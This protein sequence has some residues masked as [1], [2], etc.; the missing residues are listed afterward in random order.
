M[1]L[2]VVPS[3]KLLSEKNCCHLSL[4]DLGRI[5]EACFEMAS[6]PTR[7]PG[8]VEK[9]PRFIR[10]ANRRRVLFSAESGR[11]HGFPKP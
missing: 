5:I 9:V 4:E 6:L 8:P 1:P 7:S 2:W 10:S 11:R 3:L